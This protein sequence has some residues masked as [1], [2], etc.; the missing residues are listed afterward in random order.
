[1]DGN[2]MTINGFE[3]CFCQQAIEDNKVDPLDLALIINEEMKKNISH[4]STLNLY[5]HSKCLHDKLHP[6]YRGYLTAIIQER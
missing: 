5:A 2:E 3:C 4:R 1:M 6:Y